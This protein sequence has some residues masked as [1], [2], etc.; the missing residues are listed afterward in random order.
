MLDSFLTF[1]NQQGLDLLHRRTLLTISGGV[2]SVVML[3]LF[4]K[5]GLQ[6][7]MA[8]GRAVFA[9]GVLAS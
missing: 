5:A 3:N 1:I 6:A 7:G 9:N 2:D 4:Y 8:T